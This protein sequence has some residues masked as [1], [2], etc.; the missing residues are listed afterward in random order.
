M[1]P[2]ADYYGSGK[3]SAVV[4]AKAM[5]RR[6]A[7][8]AYRYLGL[9]CLCQGDF[10]EARAHLDEALRVY[11]PEHELEAKFR[12]GMDTG[13]G[14]TVYLA[15][16]HWILGE[17]RRARELIDEAVAL[18][19]ESGHVPTQVVTH[20]FKAIFEIFHGDAGAVRRDSETVIELSREHGIAQYLAAGL[21]S[22]SWARARLGDRETGVTE[23]RQALAASMEQRNKV[24][25]PLFQG[26]LAEIEAEGQGAEASLTRIDEA[27]AVAGETGEHWTDAFL[28][29]IRGEILL[30]RDPAKTASAEEAFLTAIAIAQ[31]QEARSFGLLAALALAKLYQ[32]EN[33]VAD[34]HAV[35]AAALEG[36]V[37]TPELPQI[38]EAQAL[39]T[40]L[41]EADEVKR[42]AAARE[43][44]AQTS[45]CIRTGSGVVARF[46]C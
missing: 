4:T 43:P 35:L 19:I 1:K 20:Q 40:V 25:V 17:V 32:S 46:R 33:R 22:H 30:K 24:W 38:E 23:L 9:T 13:A 7:A 21:L 26:L 29:R 3:P 6:R 36:F 45:D 39:L 11:N 15:H 10:I 12:F 5:L 27:L 31:Q 41:A 42:A 14:A 16:I 18:A 44:T 8:V 37:P 34:A 2:R 28:H